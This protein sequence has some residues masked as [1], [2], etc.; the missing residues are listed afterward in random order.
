MNSRLPQLTP[1]DGD[2]APFGTALSTSSG[3]GLDL[4][5]AGYVD[6]ASAGYVEEEYLLSGTAG[7][8]ESGEPGSPHPIDA[9]I[10]YRTRLLVRYPTD[11]AR[12]S[13]VTHVE[14]LHPHMDAG[15]SWD[16]LAPHFIRRGDAWVGVTVYPHIA[17]VMRDQVDPSRYNALL[18]PGDGTEWDIFSDALELIRGGDVGALRTSRIVLSGWSATGSFCRVFARERF[19]TA[20]G[21]LVDATAIFISSGGAGLAGYP[22]L[23]PS[24]RPVADDDERR[25][26]RDAGIPVFE[27]LSETESE[28]HREQ[29]RADSDADG[30]TYRLYQIAGAAHVEGWSGGRLTNAAAL[31]AAGVSGLGGVD[32]REQ[33]TDARSDLIARALMDHLVRAIDGVSAPVAPR[34]SYSADADSPER[35]LRRD[36]DGNVIGGIRAPWVEVPLAAYAPHGTPVDSSAAD[37]GGASWTPLADRRLAAGL[38]GTMESFSPEVVHARH[39]DARDY[40]QRFDDATAALVAERMLLAEDAAELSATASARWAA[41]SSPAAGPAAGIA[42]SIP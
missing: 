24:S 18:V 40:R 33:R 15:L 38:I 7:L 3:V 9:G 34:F 11:P 41:A 12:S 22:L 1:L 13:G 29:L 21:G 2:R 27:I 35:M 10:A 19:A 42:S 16:A 6:L 28:T 39:P 17:G 4:A 36:A 5:T 25:T 37:G 31:A 20:R 32:V 26:V 23:S 14:P 30:D 8:W